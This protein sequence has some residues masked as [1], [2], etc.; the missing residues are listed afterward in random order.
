MDE[1]LFSFS[2]Q[3]KSATHTV[4]QLQAQI[5]LEFAD[6]SRQCRL[7]DPQS[8]GR[9][10]NSAEFGNRDKRSSMAQVHELT[11]ARPF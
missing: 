4:E 5:V 11:Y 1:Q 8:Q 10:G 9:L 6:V 2:R 7:R 3:A